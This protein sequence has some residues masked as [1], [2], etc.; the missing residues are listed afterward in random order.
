MHKG[1]HD[2]CR[3]RRASLDNMDTTSLVN[4]VTNMTDRI[5]GSIEKRDKLLRDLI[6]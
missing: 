3:T 2:Y 6:T 1:E 4:N 5:V